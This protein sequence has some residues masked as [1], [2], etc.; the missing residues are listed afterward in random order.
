M[1]KHFSCCGMQWFPQNMPGPEQD[2]RKGHLFEFVVHCSAS[3]FRLA[4]ATWSLEVQGNP[5]DIYHKRERAIGRHVF[6]GGPAVA[7][8]LRSDPHYGLHGHIYIDG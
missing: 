5:H 6:V 1:A 2:P 3:F 4:V 8:A 7:P